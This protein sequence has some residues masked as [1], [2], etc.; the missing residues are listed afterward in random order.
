MNIQFESEGFKRSFD[1]RPFLFTHTLSGN[2]LFSL[3]ALYRLMQAVAKAQV[4]DK[5][6]RLPFLSPMPP[7]FFYLCGKRVEWNSP[8]F[9]QSLET[10]FDD[11]GTSKTRIKLT[12]VERYDGYK[13]L[14]A[15]C[16]AALS[17]ATGIN[18]NKSYWGISTIFISSPHEVTPY[19]MDHEVNFLLQIKGEKK[20]HLYSG[21]NKNIVSDRDLED[22]WLGG[23]PLYNETHSYDEIRLS[24]NTGIYQPPFFPHLVTVEDSFSIS[25]ALPFT[26]LNFP[27][28]E[29]YRFNA[30][31]RK[32]GITPS[33]VGENPRRDSMKSF[34]IHQAL[35]GKRLLLR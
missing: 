24:P 35:K 25:L 20:V 16:A 9:S 27:L 1:E 23:K 29:T 30:Y 10:A 8:E 5:M 11:L 12:G 31:M 3:D 26:R 32:L 33:A 21:L 2:E 15:D 13:E 18:F 34:G 28:A 14:F 19:H 7:G 4:S 6:K 17:D 22:Y